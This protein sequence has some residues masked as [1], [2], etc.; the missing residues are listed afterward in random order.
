MIAIGIYVSK[1]RSTVA[2]VAEGKKM[3][4]KPFDVLH[5]KTE[6]A[7]LIEFV[8]KFDDARVTM[9]HTGVY[10]QVVAE[11]FVRAGVRVSV[12]NPVLINKYG[13]NTLRKGSTDRSAS[14]KIAR[15][16]LDNRD[17]LRDYSTLN[18]I[19][20]NLKS[21]TRQFNFED[22]TLSAH[23]NRLYSL[24]ER[25]FPHIDEFFG[26]PAK[27]NGHQKLVDFVIEFWHSD[28]VSSLSLAKFTEKFRKFCRKNRYCFSESDVVKIHTISRENVTTLQKDDFTKMLVADAAKQVLAISIR[29]EKLRAEMIKLAKQTPE[30]PAVI[31]LYGVGETLASKLIAEIQDPRRFVDKWAL[32][33]YAGVDPGKDDSGKKIAKSGKISRPGDALLRKAAYQVVECHLLNSPADESVYQF[34]DKKRWEGKNYYVYMTAAC[35]KFLRIYYGRVC[36]YLDAIETETTANVSKSDTAVACINTVQADENITAFTCKQGSAMQE[37][38]VSGLQGFAYTNGAVSGLS[39][40]NCSAHSSG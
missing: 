2:A 31:E 22:K 16:T 10:Y 38:N 32:V 33:A 37:C 5:N 28:C 9:E 40:D 1:G 36:E 11:S 35:N 23:T 25:A 29:V 34:L 30:F 21:L 19:R 18:T 4:Q 7:D 24:L 8:K 39:C 12:V 17:K 27:A 26:S 3:L 6:L 14:L 20:D 15:Y 13:D